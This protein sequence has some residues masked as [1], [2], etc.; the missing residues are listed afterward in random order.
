MSQPYPPL[1]MADV[2]YL[3]TTLRNREV[4]QNL[5]A[6]VKAAYQVEG[7]LLGI[8]VGEPENVNEQTLFGSVP[9]PT[10]GAMNDLANA[11]NDFVGESRPEG[12]GAIG[13]GHLLEL[14]LKYAPQ[15]IALIMSLLEKNPNVDPATIIS[16]AG[17]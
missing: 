5:K 3:I 14:F 11:L 13:D 4:Q 8:L 1:N 10:Y 15:I 17:L 16:M 6:V 2:T 12:F 9:S 7:A